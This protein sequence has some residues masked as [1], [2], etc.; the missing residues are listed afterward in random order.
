[1][2]WASEQINAVNMMKMPDLLTVHNSRICNDIFF[3][4]DLVL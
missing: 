1:M 3:K 4:L 2:Y